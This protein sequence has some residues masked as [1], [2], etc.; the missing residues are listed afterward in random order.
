MPDCLK[1]AE[2]VA[3]AQLSPQQARVLAWLYVRSIGAE[4]EDARVRGVA[5][6]TGI[7][8]YAAKRA[9]RELRRLGLVCT[10][11]REDEGEPVTSPGGHKRLPAW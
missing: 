4:Y 11:R 8:P 9:V 3:Q 5:A 1:L 10:S 2:A 7:Q 6:G